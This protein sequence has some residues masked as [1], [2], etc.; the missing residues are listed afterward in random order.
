M[1]GKKKTAQQNNAI[2]G[3]ISKLPLSIEL[4]Y[5]KLINQIMLH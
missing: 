4:V 2:Y 5:L 3:R 1:A